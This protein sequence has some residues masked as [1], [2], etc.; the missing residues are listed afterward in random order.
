MNEHC[1]ITTLSLFFQLGGFSIDVHNIQSDTTVMVGIRVI[2]GGR[3]LER[4][5]SAIEIFGRTKQV[6]IIHLSIYLST[7][8]TM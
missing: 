4:A 5:P 6:G 1:S 8:F 7:V 2:L 3:S